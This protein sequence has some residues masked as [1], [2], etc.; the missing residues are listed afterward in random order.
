MKPTGKQIIKRFKETV[1]NHDQSRTY[2]QW[3]NDGIDKA[4]MEENYEWAIR[5]TDILFRH[6]KKT[7]K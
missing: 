5:L 2:A 7:A 4:L 6:Q 1:S 3:L